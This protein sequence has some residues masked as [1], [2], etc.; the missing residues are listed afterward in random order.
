MMTAFSGT[1]WLVTA[2]VSV[3]TLVTA[4]T[5][6]SYPGWVGWAVG[7]SALVLGFLVGGVR[8]PHTLLFS[9]LVG[10][11]LVMAGA[12]LYLQAFQRFADQR[13]TRRVQALTW[14]SFALIL[15]ALY[16][17]T[18]PWP[19]IVLRFLLVCSFLVVINIHLLRLM[20]RQIR[21]NRA[22]RSAYV[23]NLLIL[24]LVNVLTVPRTRM[25]TTG[26]GIGAFAMNGP[27]VLLH[28]GALLLSVGGA[29]A[30]WLLHDDRRRLEMQQMHD[31]LEVQ[32]TQD[33]L[34]ALLNRRG[35]EQAFGRW[36]SRPQARSAVLLL[37]DIDGFKG[38]NDGQGHAAGDE[39]LIRLAQA[40]RGSVRSGDVLGRIGGDEFVVMFSGEEN[41]AEQAAE[42]FTA[43]LMQFRLGYT[44]SVGAA[45]VR[46][47]DD[48]TDV[49][50]RADAA[51]YAQKNLLNPRPGPG[52]TAPSGRRSQ[53][54]ATDAE[55]HGPAPQG[56]PALT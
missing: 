39:C 6:P 7:H 52:V 13:P 12:V 40:L 32:A 21:Q 22:L 31:L 3:I 48:L 11:G 38:I 35:L 17:L 26:A 10:N 14:A 51:M 50:N 30:F 15:T 46:P 55:P 54:A 2:L 34:T 44:V 5:R 8:T 16:V 42:A 28:G 47:G 9:V 56:Q 45:A 1:V 49:M 23:A 41:R 37:M 36:A 18:V 24:A 27:N 20:I 19:S 25:M 43:R 53:A 33:P 29:F 4:W